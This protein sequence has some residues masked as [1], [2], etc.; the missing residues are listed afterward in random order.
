MSRLSG[1]LAAHGAGH[2]SAA[3]LSQDPLYDKPRHRRSNP[4]NV[5]FNTRLARNQSDNFLSERRDA[6]LSERMTR[7]YNPPY[8]GTRS[9]QYPLVKR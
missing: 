3:Y 6:R 8:Y 4:E 9:C 5:P 2:E 1:Y 7:G